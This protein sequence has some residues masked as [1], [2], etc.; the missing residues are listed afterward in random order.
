[1]P[2]RPVLALALVAAVAVGGAASAAAKKQ[3]KP[4]APPVC[5]QIVDD[6]GDATAGAISASNEPSWDLV[7]GDIGTDAKTLTTVI[8]VDKLAKSTSGDPLGSQWRFDFFVGETNLYTQATSTPFGDRFVVG[9]TDTTS[10]AIASSGATGVFDE[11]KNEVRVSAPLSA[12]DAQAK[13]TPGAKL[14]QLAAQAG[15]YVNTAGGS[16]SGSFAADDAAGAKPYAAGTP[17]CVAVGK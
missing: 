5:N 8:R 7:S 12:F 13:I 3:A 9:Y 1:V 2:I 4:P 15:D 11:A 16:P 17:T 10:H 14:T 6:K